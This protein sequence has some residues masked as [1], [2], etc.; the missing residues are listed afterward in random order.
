[1][2][3]EWHAQV[4]RRARLANRHD[5]DWIAHLADRLGLTDL[6][7][8]YPEYLSGGLQQRVAIGRA[9]GVRP[10]LLLADE[11]SGNLDDETGETVMDILFDLVKTKEM[12]MILVTHSLEL[13]N[14]CSK[15]LTLTRGALKN[16]VL[17]EIH[18]P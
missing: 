14:R 17:D 1:M 10:K 4:A 8:R 16:H 6:M 18:S 3:E 11:P 13:A 12:T 2:G 5:P 7:H 15:V 9:L